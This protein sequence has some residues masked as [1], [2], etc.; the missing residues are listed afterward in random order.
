MFK[1]LENKIYRG[2]RK[3]LSAAKIKSS[4]VKNIL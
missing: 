1:A 3:N 2:R 4:A